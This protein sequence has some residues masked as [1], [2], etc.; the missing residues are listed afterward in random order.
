[1]NF[2][3]VCERWNALYAGISSILIAVGS[4][5]RGLPLFMS[6]RPKTPLRVLCVMAF[7]TLHMLRN[8]KPL[9]MLKTQN[10]GGIARFRGLR[11]C[12]FR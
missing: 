8:A 3:A 11:Q 7:D 10:A 5:V 1:M 12:G 4:I 9:P 2:Q 6:A